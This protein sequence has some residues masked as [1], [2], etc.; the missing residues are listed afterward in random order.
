[1]TRGLSLQCSPILLCVYHLG[2][3]SADDKLP[4][5]DKAAAEKISFRKDVWPIVQRHC[6]GC[7]SGSDPKGQLNMDTVSDMLKGGDSG[8]L[9]VPGK[10]DDSLLVEMIVGDDPEMP[11]QQP[12]LSLAKIQTLRHW[13][14]AGAKDDSPP[15]KNRGVPIIPKVYK[16]AP[17]MTSVALS[18]DGSL[19]AAACRSEVVLVSTQTEAPVKR[20]PTRCDLLTHVEFTPDGKTLVAA[21]GSPSRYGELSVFDVA[22]GKLLFTRRVGHDTLFRGNVAPDGST[23]ALGGAKG[24]AYVIPLNKKGDVRALELHSDW[25][26]DAAFSPDGKLLVTGSRDKTVKV[27]SVET[28]RLLRTISKSP[29]LIGAV[30]SSELFAVAAGR[31]PVLSGYEFKTALRGIEISGSGNG[32]RPVNR[33]SQYT[34]SF[35]TQ[36]GEVFDLATSGDHKLLAV[37]GGFSEVR[38]Y[39][40]ADRKRVA[41]ISKVANPVYGVALNRDGTRLAIGTSTGQVQFYEIPS[42]KLLK[43]L[44]PVPV[45]VAAK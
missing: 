6:W 12:P 2:T 13:V 3:L 26:L 4:A 28:G 37:A 16:F 40:I 45:D 43:S 23:I 5:L 27:A 8:P 35:E 31:S 38:V 22:S 15:T 19:I 41:T 39:Q 14:L 1:M 34:K 24:I 29:E 30:A 25:V 42:G 36:R 17:A 21:G 7:H 20:L 11:K 10:P 44:I 33:A 32:S 9:F 18:P